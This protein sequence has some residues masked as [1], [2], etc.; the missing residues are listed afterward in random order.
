MPFAK[1][2]RTVLLPL[3]L[4]LGTVLGLGCFFETND[5]QHLAWL[6]RGLTAAEPVR[7]V[8]LYFHGLGYLLSQLYAAVP[9]LPWYGLL[10]AALLALATVLVFAVLDRLL[11]PHLR[12]PAL[13]LTLTVFF[14][15][16]WLEHWLWFSHL[17]VA[18]LLAGAAVLF[19]AQRPGRRGVLGC[20]LLMLLAWAIRPSAAVLA[21]LAAAP[22]AVLLA[23]S[24]RQARPVLLGAAAALG[25]AT[26]ALS[27]TQSPATARF[28]A[29]DSSLAAVVD[30][31]LRRPSPRTP[32]DSLLVQ[33]VD[34]WML[35]DST[36]V[37]EAGSRR[38][39]VFDIGRYLTRVLP[40]KLGSRLP[41]L[42]RDYFA[43]LLLIALLG[44]GASRRQPLRQPVRGLQLGWVCLLLSLATVLKL[45]PRLALP[46]LDC[47][48]LANLAACLPAAENLHRAAGHPGSS[49]LL[50]GRQLRL[51]L[52]G[53]ALLCLLYGAK[54]WHR[55]QM[56]RQER[57]RHEQ[58][59]AD[60]ARRSSRHIRVLAGADDL[61]KS[62]SPFQN[63][64]LGPGPVLW[65]TGWPS[66]DPSQARL[67]YRLTGYSGQA[68]A[69][70]VLATRQ[71]ADVVWILTH[72]PARW[73]QRR[74]N[75]RLPG[76]PPAARPAVAL[77]PGLILK[78]DT[79][80]RLY[81]IRWVR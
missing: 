69:L 45:P 30:Y 25:A 70:R 74:L 65:L 8:P 78:A 66:H 72:Q 6:F 50:P 46:L 63:Y 7:A 13:V 68:D 3:G 67:Y 81:N 55:H 21:L 1:L 71:H 61:L 79:T 36:L 62:L 75:A 28:R 73:L 53:V 26:L 27:L 5:D 19:A 58:A 40:A 77:E 22:G 47:W 20:C 48:L 18:L 12:S 29:I 2:L 64:S 59:L 54:T 57:S 42:L 24:W 31:D 9:A 17:R 10:L 41:L 44:W 39:Y 60:I 37:S 80:L 52:V 51:L 11:R 23:G 16:A 32:A 15:L 33:A 34:E 4:S 49:I 56:L 35:G 38:A 43:V 76:E 14:L